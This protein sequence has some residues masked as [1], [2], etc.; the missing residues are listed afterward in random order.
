MNENHLFKRKIIDLLDVIVLT[1]IF[2]LMNY[3][4]KFIYAIALKIVA[5]PFNSIVNFLTIQG[6]KTS[7][8]YCLE[9]VDCL[10]VIVRY[11]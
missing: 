1:F 6:K 5:R 2:I 9:I 11:N 8:I 7:I 10:T 3:L 4:S